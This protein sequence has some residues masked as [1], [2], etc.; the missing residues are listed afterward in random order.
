MRVA[1]PDLWAVLRGEDRRLRNEHPDEWRAGQALE[2]L[3]DPEIPA[4][5]A[6]VPAPA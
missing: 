1:Y 4:H 5:D 6:T 2:A 3:V